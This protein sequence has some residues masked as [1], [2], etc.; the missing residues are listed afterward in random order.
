MPV[1][2]R[3][4]ALLI[5]TGCVLLAQQ[6]V[7]NTQVG[8]TSVSTAAAGVQKVG[9]VGNA[10]ATVDQAPGSAI[11]TNA[12][13]MGVTD[14][15]NTRV[16]YMDPCGFSAWTYFVVNV[17]ANTQIIAGSASKNVY[18]CEIMFPPQAATVNV[19]LVESAT[20]GNACATSPTGMLG[21]AT[22]ALG[23]NITPNGGYIAI[24][25]TRAIAKTATTADAMCIFA[26]AAVNGVIGYVQF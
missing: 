21:G 10:G 19:N 26:S 5:L 2:S 25:Q 1:R 24:G 15:T 18:V 7:N 22:A 23:A 13:Q 6:P 8:G 3:R 20:S 9:I 14:G 12:V 4:I 11:P 17:S 16:P